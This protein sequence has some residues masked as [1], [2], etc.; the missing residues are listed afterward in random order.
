MDEYLNHNASFIRLYDEYKKYGSLVIGV[1]FDGTLYDYHQSGAKY[2]L[3]TQLVKDL[4]ELGCKIII[5][6]ANQDLEFVNRYCEL[7]EI[8]IN[9]I[10]TDGISLGWESRKP[11]FSAL[12]DD[13]A[14]LIQVYQ[15]LSLLV[16]ILK[17]G[18]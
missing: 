3:V 15:E 5:W 14:G 8:P 13:R 6:T 4:H 11:F 7:H 18:K 9:G 12:L 2:K 16:T 10:N 17:K 1:D